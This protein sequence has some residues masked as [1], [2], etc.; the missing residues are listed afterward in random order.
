MARRLLDAV[1]SGVARLV[2]SLFF[3]SVEV[4]GAERVPRDGPLLVVANHPNSLIDPVLLLGVLPRPVRFLGKSTLWEMVPLRPFLALGGVIPIYRPTDPGVDPSKNV[5]TFSR[6]HEALCRGAAVALFPEGTSHAD[7]ALRP[8]K[9]GAARIALGALAD[10]ATEGTLELGAAS[11]VRILPVGLAFDARERFR[12][13]ALVWVG[14]PIEVAARPDDGVAPPAPDPLDPERVRGLTATLH[15]GLEEV[16]LNYRSWRE[17][18]LFERAVEI[19]DR[20][21]RALPGDRPLGEL[22]G[23]ARELARRFEELDRSMPEET[24]R[25]ARVMG[26]YDRV[27]AALS[28]RDDQVAARYPVLRV[29]LWTSKSLLAVLVGLPLAVAGALLN[30]LPFFVVGRLANRPDLTIEVRATWKLFGGMF[31]YPVLWIAQ[32]AVA[33]WWWGLGA[34]TALV[35]AAPLAG[36]LAVAAWERGERLW[37]EARAYLLL[38]GRPHLRSRLQDLRQRVRQKVED[39]ARIWEAESTDPH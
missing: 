25:V 11:A 36:Y 1:S 7:P 21:S 8:L 35:A 28:L 27:L 6:C 3:R 37:R 32:G 26:R 31:A 13:R 22:H 19:Y 29:L 33:A 23:M 18:R 10:R 20:P 4:V 39:L 38:R 12:S 16:T 9:T 5:E 2:L 15:R 30:A 17:A 24:S 14:E 34:G